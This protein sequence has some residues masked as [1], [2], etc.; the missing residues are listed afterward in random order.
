MIEIVLSPEEARVLGCLIEKQIT[1]PEYYPMSLNSLVAACNQK[2]N[3]NPVVAWDE[4]TVVRALD[5]LRDKKLAS[6]I[7]EAG[8][9]VPKYKH[10]ADEIIG[11]DE[12]DIAVLCELLVRGPQTVG[13]LRTR[14]ERMFA[15]ADLAQVQAVLDGFAA[16]QP[17]LVAKLPRQPGTKESRHMHLLSGAPPAAPE[18]AEAVAPV[19]PARIAVQADNER[20]A[21]LEADVAA[22][23]DEIAALR[24]QLTDFQKKFE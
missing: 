6:M 24:Q 20:I 22:L 11:L 9:R 2:N 16:R 5:S 19:E 10:N 3:R 1:T 13:E 14:G 17:P 21:K 15:F 4:K 8:A 7:S 18:G 23:R 12:K